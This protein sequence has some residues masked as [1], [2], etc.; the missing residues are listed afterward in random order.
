MADIAIHWSH[1]NL[2]LIQRSESR[3]FSRYET[4]GIYRVDLKRTE[5]QETY[6]HVDQSSN[7][8]G[9]SPRERARDTERRRLRRGRERKLQSH[10]IDSWQS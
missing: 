4:L 3:S 2:S 5:K 7:K 9:T 10:M 1:D 6:S 8:E